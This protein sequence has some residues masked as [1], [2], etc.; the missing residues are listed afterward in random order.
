M[1]EPMRPLY[2]YYRRLKSM[3]TQAESSN[4]KIR[5]SGSGSDDD[6]PPFAGQGEHLAT[7]HEEKESLKQR[8]AA[9][10]AIMP[11]RF[12]HL[13]LASNLCR[14]KRALCVSSCRH[15]RRSS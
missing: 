7:V 12:M 4:P 8:P 13:R 11:S 6:R 2:V 10:E 14:T 1:G 15:S 3:I 5:R 9:R